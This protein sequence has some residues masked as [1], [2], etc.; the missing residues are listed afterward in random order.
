MKNVHVVVYS[1]LLFW[2]LSIQAQQAATAGAPVRS[3]SGPFVPHQ[4][5]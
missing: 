5:R 3:L 2:C 4:R 1:A